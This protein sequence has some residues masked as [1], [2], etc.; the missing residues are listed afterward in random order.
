M[1]NHLTV[2]LEPSDIEE[3]RKQAA[4]LALP[5]HTYLRSIVV[6]ALRSARVTNPLII[7][8]E[9]NSGGATIDH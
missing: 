4:I 7:A 9:A 5:P 1:K 3:L 8:S 6:T 2:N